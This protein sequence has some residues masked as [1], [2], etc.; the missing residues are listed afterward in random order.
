MRC[1]VIAACVASFASPLAA[2]PLTL[3]SGGRTDCEIV[4]PESTGDTMRKWARFL[5]R[6]LHE[7]TGADFPVV[8]ASVHAADKPSIRMAVSLA[9]KAKYEEYEIRTQGRDVI[10]SGCGERGQALAVRHFLTRVCGCRWYDGWTRKIPK[11]QTLVVPRSSVRRAPSFLYRRVF[12]GSGWGK[13][14]RWKV[15]PYGLPK[16]GADPIGSPGDVHT[17]FEF[18]KDWPKERLDLLSM[19]PKGKRRPLTSAQ[20]PNFCM[21][22]PEVRSR[23]KRTLRKFIESDRHEAEKSGADAPFIYCLSHNDCQHYY[24]KCPGCSAFESAHGAGGLLLDFVNDVARDVAAVYPDV[25]LVTDAYGFAEEP[26]KGGMVAEPNVLVEIARTKQNYYSPAEEDR[27]ELFAGYLKGWSG[28][29]RQLGVWDYWVFYW[30]TFPA[31]YHNVPFIKRNLKWYHDL[32]ARM[33]RMESEQPNTAS[34][35]SLKEWLGYELML[36]IDQDDTALICEFMTD[37]YGAAAPEMKEFMDLLTELQKGQVGKVFVKEGEYDPAK[38]LDVPRRKWLDADFYARAED[39][40]TRALRKVADADAQTRLNVMRERIPVD[41]SLLYVYDIIR[42]AVTCEEVVKR[43]LENREAQYRLRIDES[44]LPTALASVRAEVAKLTG[45]NKTTAVKAAKPKEPPRTPEPRK[46]TRLDGGAM[47][48]DFDLT[49]LSLIPEKTGVRI[50]WTCREPNMA[51]IHARYDKG[52]WNVFSGDAV[53]FYFS[54]YLGG[55]A[56]NMPQSQYRFMMNPAGTTLTAY[57]D[58]KW[59]NG[60]ISAKSAFLD[61]SW[62]SDWFIPYAALATYEARKT[63]KPIV[64]TAH[65]LFKAKRMRAATGRREVLDGGELRLTLPDG[66]IEPY[67]RVAL[68]KCRVEAG[69]TPEKVKVTA[70]LSEMAGKAFVGRVRFQLRIGSEKRTVEVRDVKLKAGAKHEMSQTLTL[71]QT[72][73]RFAAYVAVEDEELRLVRTSRGLPI[74]NPWVE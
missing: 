25:I 35:R 71:P 18:S 69:D 5:S 68:G 46:V 28:I 74:A 65:W 27:G 41:L 26:P 29:A 22:N 38:K 36:D 4:L 16:L 47:R 58:P 21:T 8:A 50:S 14:P 53:D 62:K 66:V 23:I 42:P 30:D 15:P 20:G 24:C 37:F 61:G 43:Y 51:N 2:E 31:P 7:M 73:E 60:A 9:G 63:E 1:L 10:L 3:A 45:T 72:S 33:V 70:V 12:Q 56:R 39:V 54:P 59:R 44:V 13:D 19:S 52:D 57:D 55:A 34:F 67:G 48:L 64:P 17:F 6:T 40:F 49:S 11:L 32:G